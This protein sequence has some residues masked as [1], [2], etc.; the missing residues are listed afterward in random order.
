MLSMSFGFRSAMRLT[1]L[2]CVDAFTPA[3][4]VARET[5]LAP[6]GMLTSLTTTPSTT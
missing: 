4:L 5:E 1:M 6:L 2:S 3:V